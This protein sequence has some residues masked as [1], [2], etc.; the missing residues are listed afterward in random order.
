[1]DKIFISYSK[2]AVIALTLVL[3]SLEAVAQ[4]SKDE[5]VVSAIGKAFKTSVDETFAMI[6]AT[7]VD[8]QCAGKGVHRFGL[9]EA[10]PRS[11]D[12]TE[13][14]VRFYKRPVPKESKLPETSRWTVVIDGQAYLNWLLKKVLDPSLEPRS[15]E[16]NNV[17]I[18]EREIR[19]ENKQR[20]SETNFRSYL[21]LKINRLT[22]DITLSKSRYSGSQIE[23]IEVFSGTCNKVTQRF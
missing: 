1:V 11:F 15:G 2:G 13:K 12:I 14:S 3:L 17:F 4:K 19:V 16:L 18:N 6:T 21:D 7:N 8:L 22:G 9:D 20:S 23:A 10:Y 5:E